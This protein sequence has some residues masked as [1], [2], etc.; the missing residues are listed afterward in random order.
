MRSIVAATL[1]LGAC[2][3]VSA[4][5]GVDGYDSVRDRLASSQTRLRVPSTQGAGSITASRYTPDGWQPG[6]AVLSVA[7]GEL[8]AS[9]DE[10]GLLQLSKLDASI[11]PIE[12]PQDVFGKPARLTDLHLALASQSI[13]TTTWTDDDNAI[14]TMTVELDATWAVMFDSGS[15]PLATQHLPPFPVELAI[16]GGGDHVD[17]T[18]AIHGSGELWS[19]AGL[20]KLLDLQLA[21][22]ASSIDGP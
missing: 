10:A 21:F 6:T 17:A 1:C 7:S 18:I 16:T 8:V 14:A 13:A 11:D 19:W 5:P 4:P 9:V 15:L 20:V 3:S 12:I 2:T 22:G